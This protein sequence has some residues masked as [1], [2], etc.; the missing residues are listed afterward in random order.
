M[1]CPYCGAEMESGYIQCRDGVFWTPKLQFAAA[2]A[3]MAKGATSLENGAA[4]NNRAT[5]AHKCKSCRK[6]IIEY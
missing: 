1:N 5:H 3:G 4:D 2:L 6:I